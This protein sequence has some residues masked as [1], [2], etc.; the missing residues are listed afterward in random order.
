MKKLRFSSETRFKTWFLSEMRKRGAWCEKI[1]QVAIRGTPD[2]LC[3]WNGVFIAAEL[4]KDEGTAVEPLQLVKLE[5]IRQAGGIAELVWPEVALEVM[6][7]WEEA[8][9]G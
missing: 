8:V 7:R 2:V 9:S 3:C 1:D 6:A 4:K 5:Q